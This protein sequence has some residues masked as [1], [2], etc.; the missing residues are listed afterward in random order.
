VLGQVAGIPTSPLEEEDDNDDNEPDTTRTNPDDINM[1][2]C[3]D[4][5]FMPVLVSDLQTGCP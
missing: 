3:H 4:G 1:T 5:C 2:V